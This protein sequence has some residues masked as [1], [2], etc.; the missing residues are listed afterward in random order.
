MDIVSYPLAQIHTYF[1]PFPL[2]PNILINDLRR[3]IVLDLV[4]LSD[5]SDNVLWVREQSD[6]GVVQTTI[7]KLSLLSTE[8]KLEVQSSISVIEFTIS[9]R[10]AERDSLIMSRPEPAV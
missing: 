3:L 7:G 5:A 4:L 6:R 2:L 10:L 9:S 8:L 1:L